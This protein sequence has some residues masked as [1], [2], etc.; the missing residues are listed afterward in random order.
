MLGVGMGL[1][2]GVVD[3]AGLPADVG[4][5]GCQISQIFLFLLGVSMGGVSMRYMSVA[6]LVHGVKVLICCPN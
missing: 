6:M 4:G 1:S 2:V 3:G 5:C